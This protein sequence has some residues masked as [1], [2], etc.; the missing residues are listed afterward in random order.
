[1]IERIF[2]STQRAVPLI[3]Q[4]TWD[5]PER[6]TAASAAKRALRRGI[7]LGMVH[8]DTAEMYGNGRVE[9]AVADAI[10][11]LPRE[12]LLLT[13]KALPTNATFRGILAACER[14]LQRLRT[15]YVD[16]YLLHWPSEY[17]LAE[18]M[19]GLEQLV[20]D[21]KSRAIG[22]SNFDVRQL[23]VAQRHLTREKMACNQV[24]YHMYERGIEQELLPYC[25]AHGIAVVGY[26]PFGRG[27]F[28][29][30]GSR[31]G[32]VLE[33]IGTKYGKTPRQVI[34][35]FLTREPSTF[36]IPKA[37][38]EKHVEENAA[39]VGWELSSE[40]VGSLDAAFPVRYRGRLATL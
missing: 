29:S 7:E 21:G 26:T 8:I 35:N 3:G 25:T 28:P 15:D 32:K 24:L 31:E 9:E 34:L 30:A 10:A 4:G 6:G 14:S 18:T 38:T 37:S 39:S 17:P 19:R 12:Q 33:H 23:R 22:V 20:A 11:G 36:A 40:D 13:T 27:K 1:M 5:I 16:L 2:G